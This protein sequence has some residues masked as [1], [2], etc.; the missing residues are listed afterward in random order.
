MGQIHVFF[1]PVMA[2]GHMIPTLDMAKL[3]ASRGVKSTIITT[4][5]NRTVFAGAVQ[6]QTGL[7]QEIEL[8]L[9][10]FPAAQVG[11]PEDC[12]RFDQLA[13]HDDLPKFMKACSMLQEPFER[14][15]EELRPHCVVADTFFPWATAS[16]AKFDIPSLVF[17]GTNA[18]SLCATHSLN[19]HKPY[20]SVSSDSDLFAIPDLPHQVKLTRL[21]VS[22][23]SRGVPGE[24]SPMSG[25]MKQISMTEE[26]S[27]GVIFNSF[28]ELEPEYAEHYR[29]VLGRRSWFVGPLSLS[30]RDT[31]DKAQRGEKSSIGEKECLEWL[32][33]KKPHSV[34]YVCFGSV[35]S[36][37]DSQLREMAAGIEASGQEFIWAIRTPA[38]EEEWMPEGFEERTKG[39]G[40]VIRG[41]AP[42]VLILDHGS[43]GAFVTHCGWN[44]TLEAVCA[45]VPMVTWPVFAEQFINEKLVTDILQ[46]GVGVGSKKWK[47]LGSEGVK[48]EA[49]S[50]TIKKVMV[51]EEADEMRNRAKALKEKAREAV[52]EGGS[53]HSGLSD[54]L[55][56][57]RTYHNAKP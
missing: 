2:Q 36:F 56:E 27:F 44:S 51:G 16:A 6:K 41:W 37:A 57:L 19:T 49:V 25:I 47:R 45:G 22:P 20:L 35:A 9:L 40:L 3:F 5:L 48:R 13:S 11:L 53:S 24:E 28:Y 4:P 17:H 38:G 43:V 26:T 8:R 32:D 18:F 29:N 33:S 21:Q 55:D 23:F 15:L 10:D 7:G 39:K 31:E 54:L 1:I 46:T 34:V 14:L 52:E 42:Q 12:Q 50:E 30:N